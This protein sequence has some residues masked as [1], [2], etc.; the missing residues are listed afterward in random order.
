M[1]SVMNLHYI[2][3]VCPLPVHGGKGVRYTANEDTP[4]EKCKG[5]TVQ[6]SSGEPWHP[7]DQ[8]LIINLVNTNFWLQANFNYHPTLFSVLMQL[9]K[10]EAETAVRCMFLCLKYF[11]AKSLKKKKCLSDCNISN[12][13]KISLLNLT[14]HPL[15]EGPAAVVPCLECVGWC[16]PTI[17]TQN[18]ESQARS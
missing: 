18:T 15:R 5:P 4:P 11:C 14:N 3:F 10:T 6:R 17:P 8:T 16:I 9:F 13:C 1:V 7:S 2:S 12:G